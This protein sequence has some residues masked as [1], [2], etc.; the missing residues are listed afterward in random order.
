MSRC[1]QLEVPVSTSV[2]QIPLGTD[3]VHDG[4][5]ENALVAAAQPLA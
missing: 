5:V 3:E 1:Q 4:Y 2:R